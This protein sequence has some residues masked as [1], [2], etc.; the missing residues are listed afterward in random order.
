MEKFIVTGK[1]KLSGTFTP[2]GNKNE[3]L[4]ILC[5]ALLT[6]FDVTINNLPQI[7]D[8]KNMCQIIEMLGAEINYISAGKVVISPKNLNSSLPDKEISKK[9]RGSFL[10]L[11][12]LLYRF[13]KVEIPAPG[14]D[15]IGKRRLDTHFSILSKLGAEVVEKNN[16][17]TL[18]ADKLVGANIF[19]DESS[20]MATENAVMACAVSTGDSTIYNAACEPH[21][22]GLCLMLNNM[23]AKITGIGSNLLYISGVSSLNG[24]NHTIQNDHI[25]IGSIIGLA[26]VLHS[27][28][29]IA[30][31]DNCNMGLI[32][33]FYHKLGVNFDLVDNHFVVPAEQEL[34]IKRDDKLRIP[35]ID[36][37]PWPGFPSDLLS[38]ILMVA[39]QCRG[40]VLIFEKLFE[41]RLFWVDKL[42]AMGA[43]IVLCDP[44]RAIINGPSRLTAERITSPDIRAGMALLIAAL[45]AEGVSEIYNIDQID[46][47]Y[48]EID[49]KLNALGAGIVRI[50]E[51]KNA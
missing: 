47:G 23:G 31:A 17:Y 44:H 6:R 1:Q 24:V 46:R 49:K 27:P 29:K 18:K 51:N 9:I 37:A 35:K 11:A 40:T 25:E 32:P 48:E 22:Q 21:V 50:S 20:V 12:P 42:I 36:D 15:A 13:G 38:I 7:G 10:L 45:A 3:A 43:E 41:S 28:L 14:G 4:A 30:G 39:T 8:V 33:H 5:A 16:I 19:L 34:V 26:A 2:S